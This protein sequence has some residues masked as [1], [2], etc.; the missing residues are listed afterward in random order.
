MGFRSMH[1]RYLFPLFTLEQV[2]VALLIP[3]MLLID[4]SNQVDTLVVINETVR[5]IS[6]DRHIT[7]LKDFGGAAS[8]DKMCVDDFVVFG[9]SDDMDIAVGNNN[10][11][12]VIRKILKLLELLYFVVFALDVVQ[13]AVAFLD[14]KNGKP[15]N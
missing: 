1:G 2:L 4:S 14:G 6:S 12:R 15:C 3:L 8:K 9:A 5:G 10:C 11:F 13:E 7:K